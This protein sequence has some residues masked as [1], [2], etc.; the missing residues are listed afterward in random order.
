[1]VLVRVSAP[2]ADGKANEAVSRLIARSL[3]VARGRVAIVR[4]VGARE[5]TVRVEGLSGEELKSALLGSIGTSDG[6]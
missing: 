5:K 1:M 4:G 3:G 6:V 2:P